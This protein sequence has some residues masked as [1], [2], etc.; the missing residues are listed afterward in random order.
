MSHQSFIIRLQRKKPWWLSPFSQCFVKLIFTPTLWPHREVVIFSYKRQFLNIS[1]EFWMLKSPLCLC[2]NTGDPPLLTHYLQER[3]GITIKRK[4]A[5][6]IVKLPLKVSTHPKWKVWCALHR[7]IRV[8]L[9]LQIFQ[10][11]YISESSFDIIILQVEDKIPYVSKK[12]LLMDAPCPAQTQAEKSEETVKRVAESE[13][14]NSRD[15]TFQE[16]TEHFF[17][18]Q[19]YTCPVF[20][21]FILLVLVK[22]TIL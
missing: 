6:D 22:N 1:S 16:H 15:E 8:I 20:V 14:M 4:K 13:G 3:L 21:I 5:Q 10:L 18:T 19:V 12:A 7:W 17:V 2:L 9:T 11:L